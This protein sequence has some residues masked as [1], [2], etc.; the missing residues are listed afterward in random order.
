MLWS[1]IV[2]GMHLV[3]RKE[4]NFWFRLIRR[5]RFPQRSISLKL[6]CSQCFLQQV[7]KQTLDHLHSGI[8][9]RLKWQIK[10]HLMDC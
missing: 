9:G 2:T 10:I 1:G 3:I 5:E 8:L 7:E 6:G 4:A